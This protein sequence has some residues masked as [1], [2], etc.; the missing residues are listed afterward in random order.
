MSPICNLKELLEGTA[1]I[2]IDPS[3]LRI[4]H[5]PLFPADRRY[6]I[7]MDKVE[8]LKK[9]LF[10]AE[11]IRVYKVIVKRDSCPDVQI[12]EFD[13]AY[14]FEWCKILESEYLKNGE[15]ADIDYLRRLEKK[16][17][18]KIYELVLGWY[19]IYRYRKSDD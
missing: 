14:H 13:Y 8:F 1:P 2:E 4:S 3:H 10:L 17:N 16:G 9:H 6:E 12:D 11:Q 7:P 18:R 5:L 15:F 19:S